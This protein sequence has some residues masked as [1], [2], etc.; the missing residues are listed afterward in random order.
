MVLKI[1][2]IV[3]SLVFEGLKSGSP[4]IVY[5][6]PVH[7]RK[8]LAGPSLQ[9][10]IRI[11]GLLDSSDR[12]TCFLP[13]AKHFILLTTG[14]RRSKIVGDSLKAAGVVIDSLYSSPFE[15][16]QRSALQVGSAYGLTAVE[17]NKFEFLY[18]FILI[19][20]FLSSFIFLCWM[21]LKI[22]C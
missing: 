4:N 6:A 8:G 3:I 17:V 12:V 11:N 2:L 16:C 10:V 20:K 21:F 15:R 1:F 7:P 14:L 9:F 18:K 13:I 22:K 5:L 19:L